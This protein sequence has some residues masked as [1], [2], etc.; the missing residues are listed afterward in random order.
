MSSGADGDTGVY[1]TL[2]RHRDRR[3]KQHLGD[4]EFWQ[5]LLDGIY[6]DRQG[7][8]RVIIDAEDSAK[9]VGK[10]GLAIFLARVLAERFDWPLSEAD[11]T[12]SGAEYLRRAR[13]HPGADQ[14]SVIVLD[15]L[16]GAGA[17]HAYR[18]MSTQNVQL[19]NWWQLMRAKRIVTLTTLPHWSKASK[20]MR[21]E[22]EFRLH[23]LKKPMGYFKA[24]EV[25]TSFG[26]GDI[27]TRSLDDERI[28]F[29]DIPSRGDALYRTLTERKD[30]L[31]AS[32]T[33]TDADDL[34]D[35]D[36]EDKLD[37]EEARKEERKEIA[38]R[39]RDEGYTLREVGDAVD[40]SHTWVSDHVG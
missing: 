18:E 21:R 9:G 20:Q 31:L 6:G 26:D 13:E 23:C 19:G 10:T 22:A 35:E 25:T 24:Y 30:A 29:P 3:E 4:T 38:E 1:D 11:L 36:G 27:R 14:P 39:M 8:A 5:T 40:H 16:A 37:P 33:G 34:L 7:D 32:A 28:R 12:L 17:G 15:E 2:A